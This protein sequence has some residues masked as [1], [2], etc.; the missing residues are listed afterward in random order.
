VISPEGEQLGIL[1]LAEA[2][3]KSEEFGL[4]LVEVAPNVDPPV[5]KIM[6]YGKFRYEESK[7]EHERKKKQATVILK[8]IK[9]RPK[10]EEHDLDYKV[11]RLKR[12]IADNC[13]VKV[14][15]MFRGREIT[16][17]EQARLLIDRVLDLVGDEVQV[18]QSAKFEGRNMTLVLAPK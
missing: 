14:T 16:H 7:K 15:V 10:T 6:D 11:K 13:K 4:D 9:L 5:C 18:E 17:P 12:F 3:A 2:L 1:D 8:E